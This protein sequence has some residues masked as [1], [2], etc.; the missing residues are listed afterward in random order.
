[1]EAYDLWASNDARKEKWLA[2]RPICCACGEHIQDEKA[3]YYND[4]WFHKDDDCERALMELVWE[5]IKKDY[6]EDVEEL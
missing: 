4:Q 6:L 1:M 2:S 3:F 5:D